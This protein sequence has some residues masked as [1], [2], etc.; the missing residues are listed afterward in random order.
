[1][2]VPVLGGVL[3]LRRCR[4]A[5]YGA[6]APLGL[7]A[8]GLAGAAFAGAVSWAPAGHLWGAAG[9]VPRVGRL[10]STLCAL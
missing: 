10:K 7:P 9:G 1:M 4:A 8:A 3:P 6:A 2:A 5:A